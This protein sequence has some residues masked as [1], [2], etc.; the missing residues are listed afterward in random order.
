MITVSVRSLRRIAALAWCAAILVTVDAAPG[1]SQSLRDLAAAADQ[2]MTDGEYDQAVELYGQAHDLAPQRA[3]IPYN[4][5]VAQYRRGDFENAA[6]WFEQAAALADDPALRSMATYNLG[7]AN[8]SD[9]MR[10]THSDADPQQAADAMAG[11]QDATDR[12]GNAL[13]HYRNVIDNDPADADARANA[14]LAHRLRKQL[15]EMQ[16]QLQEQQQ[17]QQQQQDQQQQDQRDQQQQDQQSSDQ[18]QEDRQQQDQQVDRDQPQGRDEN[19]DQQSPQSE[20]GEQDRQQQ[21]RPQEQEQ[22][23]QQSGNESQDDREE[24]QSDRN[25]SQ[26]GDRGAAE[27]RQ[28]PMSREEAERLLQRVRDQERERRAELARRQ[29]SRHRPAEKDW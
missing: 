12:L 10:K 23:Q 18:Q 20:E 5:A 1:Q 2:A 28:E 4:L 25:E 6:R 14:E 22:E 3:E 16:E 7:N 15:E 27:Q 13:N 11:L 8:F 19:A 24:P 29:R 26:E 21:Q 9:A 17:Q